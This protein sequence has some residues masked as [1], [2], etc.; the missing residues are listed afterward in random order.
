MGC[1]TMSVA[2][3]AAVYLLRRKGDSQE[4]RTLN[5][6]L[7]GGGVFGFI[8]HLWNG[9]LWFSGNVANDL[10]LGIAITAGITAFWAGG[11]LISRMNEGRVSACP[12]R[13][14]EDG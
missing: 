2:A 7:A 1:Y 9:E 13:D 10:L 3:A 8:D 11:V 12:Q 14:D 4:L 6:L 5:L